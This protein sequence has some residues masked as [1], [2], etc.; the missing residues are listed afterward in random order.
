[1][2]ISNIFQKQEKNT[3]RCNIYYSVADWLDLAT[4]YKIFHR[5]AI[6]YK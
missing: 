4:I 1:M 3:N 5:I 2:Q 6:I